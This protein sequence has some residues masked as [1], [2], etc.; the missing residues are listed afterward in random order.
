GR[1]A[2]VPPDTIVH[3]APPEG[4]PAGAAAPPLS[5][6]V[7][8]RNPLPVTGGR[9]PENM[10]LA[11]RI[12]PEAFRALTFRAVLDEDFEEIAERLAWVQQAGAVSRWT[13]SWLTTFVTPDPLGSFALSEA[14]RAE[15]EG[16]M[17]CVRQAGREDHGCDPVLL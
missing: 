2:N 6:I 8:V 1:R 15:L 12:M 17:D 7:A 16:L 11:R 10:E 5:G 3:L 14:R 4:A 9:D 13:G